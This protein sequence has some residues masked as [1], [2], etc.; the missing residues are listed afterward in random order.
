MK[1]LKLNIL[2]F[3]LMCVFPLFGQDHSGSFSSGEGTE[4]L[5]RNS[6]AMG[7][8]NIAEKG[9]SA[10]FGLKT[11]ATTDNSFVLGKYNIDS[12]LIDNFKPLFVIGGGDQNR[13][14][15]LLTVLEG[16]RTII[17]LQRGPG[18]WD[19]RRATLNVNGNVHISSGLSIGRAQDK[20]S[21]AEAD[22]EINQRFGNSRDD[23]GLVLNADNRRWL[24]T[25][26]GK[27]ASNSAHLRFLYKNH[28]VDKYTPRFTFSHYSGPNHFGL[29]IGVDQVKYPIHLASGAHATSGGVW[30]NASS[31]SFKEDIYNL[32]IT[33]AEKTLMLLE[34]V[35][36]KYKTEKDETYL[37]FIAEDVPDLVAT[38]DRKSL[39]AMD[40]VAVLTKVL[41]EQQETISKLEQR[42]TVLENK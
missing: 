27:G 30:T 12:P 4:A 17:G 7:S 14:A 37:G 42:I 38:K 11:K 36:F 3:S 33:D 6:V 26:G 1:K 24:I 22:L 21:P 39:S 35:Q 13:R 25:I 23:A 34:P 41:Q 19:Q 5:G 28:N 9:N 29:G 15:N 32:S 2:L 31:R 8:L 18:P 16:G 40:I 10:A 20:K